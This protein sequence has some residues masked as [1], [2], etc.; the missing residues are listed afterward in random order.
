MVLPVPAR[1]FS[2]PTRLGT[3]PAGAKITA[4][5]TFSEPIPSPSF[6]ASPTGQR[7]AF[8]CEPRG[9]AAIEGSSAATAEFGS[10]CRKSSHALAHD[11][12]R[13][14]T[15]DMIAPITSRSAL[16]TNRTILL[17]PFP[18]AR[19]SPSEKSSIPSTFSHL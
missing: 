8:S 17:F 12:I 16:F 11:S 3:S 14:T 9:S 7:L 13:F 6:A 10:R 4:R 15:C 5:S 1:Q 18:S 19:L 2:V